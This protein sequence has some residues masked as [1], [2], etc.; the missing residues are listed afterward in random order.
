MCKRTISLV[1]GKR[2]RQRSGFTLLEVLIIMAILAILMSFVF[3]KLKPFARKQQ[4][5]DLA[6]R[7]AVKSIESGVAQYVLDNM[8]LP[9]GTPTGKPTVAKNICQEAVKGTDC[10]IGAGGVDLSGL[11][12][13][14]L[15]VIPVDPAMTGA[16]VTGYKLYSDG[17]DVYA[18]ASLLGSTPSGGV[19]TSSSAGSSPSANLI[20]YWALNDNAGTAAADSSGRGHDGTLR[21][22]ATWTP[23]LSG[24][25]LQFDGSNDEMSV[26]AHADFNS[27][28][29][30]SLTA[31]VHPYSWR[32]ARIA[33]NNGYFLNL[34][35]DGLVDFA[36]SNGST[37]IT[38][39]SLSQLPLSRWTHIALAYDGSKLRLYV[40]GELD[41]QYDVPGIGK[42]V[43]DAGTFRIGAPTYFHGK[44]DD[45]RLYGISLGITETRALAAQGFP[46]SSLFAYWKFDE[47]MGN[48]A[49]DATGRGHTA[50]IQ[51]GP[52]WVATSTPPTNY[53]NAF[54]LLFNRTGFVQVPNHSDF[55]IGEGFS[56]VLWAYLDNSMPDSGFVSKMDTS[57]KGWTLFNYGSNRICL[58]INSYSPVVC[59]AY[60]NSAGW[61]HLAAVWDGS[62]AK[63]YLDGVLQQDAAASAPTNT[64]VNLFI[65]GY[66]YYSYGTQVFDD[67]I[68]D[69]RY[70][71]RALA[72][73]EIKVLFGQ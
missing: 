26:D 35:S 39:T 56:V 22:G 32:N 28:G 69:V 61:R 59:T 45:V 38:K 52:T 54:S 60:I 47:G 64:T 71:N 42:T 70:F 27:L 6:R 29:A 34:R 16:L 15:Q 14:Y 4:A 25:A 40:N 50:T 58:T 48:T 13:K 21:S 8:A 67:K 30:F 73:S 17:E 37:T 3:L 20:A 46:S 43:A 53:S 63:I 72:Y 33:G 36:V 49:A 65:G 41:S 19:G 24:S 18:L 62:R 66:S 11:A 10:T 68:D 7:A 55:T 9:P 23:G 1:S 44:I 5:F 57:A 12:P 31:W 51:S 2:P